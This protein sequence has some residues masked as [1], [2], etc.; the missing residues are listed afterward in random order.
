MPTRVLAA[1][2]ALLLAASLTACASA[3]SGPGADAGGDGIPAP[4]PAGDVVGQGT[5][6]QQ[7]DADAEFC[8]GAVAESYP[9]QCGG[10]PMPEWT[11]PEGTYEEASGVT[12]GSYAIIGR[13][14]GEAF[15]V[16]GE[17]VPLA[18]YSPLAEFDERLEEANAGEGDE[19]TLTAIQDELSGFGDDSV[20]SSWQQNGYLFVQVRYDDGTVQEWMDARYGPALVA[21]QSAL[22]DA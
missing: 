7:G 16:T 6:L 8:I 12:W 21:V 2:V 14:D 4:V 9:P 11:F 1:A 3:G 5:V 15:A 13:W 22:L 20:L 10:M 18:L 19:A 17:V